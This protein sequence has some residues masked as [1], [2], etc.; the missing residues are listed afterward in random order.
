METAHICANN[1]LEYEHH[2]DHSVPQCDAEITKKCSCL[3]NLTVFI[4]FG[5]ECKYIATY[6]T[7][8]INLYLN[9]TAA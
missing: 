3:C 6:I 5:H 1:D 7:V 9:K 4:Q 2:T 8:S